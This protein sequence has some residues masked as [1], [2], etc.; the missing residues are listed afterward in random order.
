[1]ASHDEFPPDTVDKRIAVLRSMEQ[2]KRSTAVRAVSVVA[3][4]LLIGVLV[5]SWFLVIHMV[6]RHQLSS[7]K[8]AGVT[9]AASPTV[10]PPSIYPLSHAPTGKGSISF[11]STGPFTCPSLSDLQVPSSGMKQGILASLNGLLFARSELQAQTYADRAAWPI[12]AEFWAPG[13]TQ[14]KATLSPADV[15]ILPARGSTYAPVYQNLCGTRIVADS[16]LTIW[17]TSSATD[18]PLT[19]SMCLQKQPDLTNYSYFLD[20]SGHWLLWGI[21]G[22]A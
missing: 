5:G 16:W 3:A 4:V 22:G 14:P 17:C 18:F 19:P 7:S 6:G 10:F 20:R 2:R 12:V 21:Q 9:S 15:E 13:S 8:P 1:M 11:P